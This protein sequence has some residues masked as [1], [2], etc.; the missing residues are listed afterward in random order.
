M[1]LKQLHDTAKAELFDEV[2]PFWLKNGVD[3]KWGGFICG[4]DHSGN[5]LDSSKYAWYQGRGAWVFAKL[6]ARTKQEEHLNIA[7]KALAFVEKHCK[8]DDT[9]FYTIVAK[10]GAAD[11]ERS[12]VD[13]VGY[14]SLFY[15]G[16]IC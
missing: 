7:R 3:N 5:T 1:D 9:T 14:A 4:L 15:I 2:L 8:K 16:F 11:N 12:E 13:H 10:D 6:Y